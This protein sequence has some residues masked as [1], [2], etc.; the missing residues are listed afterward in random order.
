MSFLPSQFMGDDPILFIIHPCSV[1]SLTVS[2]IEVRIFCFI[3]E[4]IF[5]RVED[6]CELFHQHHCDEES[7]DDRCDED[8]DERDRLQGSDAGTGIIH[9]ETSLSLCG[10][11][12]EPRDEKDEAIHRTQPGVEEE[13]DEVFLEETKGKGESEKGNEGNEENE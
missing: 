10:A 6:R 1:S 12:H 7:E 3:D 5:L 11:G 9:P 8:N 2:G 13:E 4:I